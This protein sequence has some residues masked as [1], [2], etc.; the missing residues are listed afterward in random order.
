MRKLLRRFFNYLRRKPVLKELKE[1]SRDLICIPPEAILEVA[2]FL[3]NGSLISLSL[4]CHAYRA[5]L[6]G[7]T[8]NVILEGPELEDFL[9]VLEKDCASSYFCHTCVRLHQRDK[10]EEVELC[11]CHKWGCRKNCLYH[12][13][14]YLRIDSG[15][16]IKYP[17]VR[18]IMNRHFNGSTHGLPLDT[19]NHQGPVLRYGDGVTRQW[20]TYAH[21]IRDEFFVQ[22]TLVAWIPNDLASKRPM[23]RV[24]IPICL[25]VRSIYTN[26]GDEYLYT[27]CYGLPELADVST[28]FNGCDNSLGSCPVC[29]TDYSITICP[30]SRQR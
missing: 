18:L 11:K 28:S 23:D 5:L 27:A 6:S 8:R 26:F 14:F 21:I 10:R 3:P 15:S 22:R 1:D 13:H 29:F 24:Y 2:E 19:L 12:F 16:M 30:E 20:T 17:D 7:L 4:T 25:H 9:Q